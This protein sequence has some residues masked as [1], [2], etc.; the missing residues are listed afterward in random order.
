MRGK[1]LRQIFV[2]LPQIHPSPR[3]TASGSVSSSSSFFSS[4][5]TTAAVGTPFSRILRQKSITSA[6]A[7]L[8]SFNNTTARQQNPSSALCRSVTPMP[9]RRSSADKIFKSA[10][11]E[12]SSAAQTNAAWRAKSSRRFF[13]ITAA[14]RYARSFSRALFSSFGRQKPSFL[15]RGAFQKTT[16]AFASSG[17][18]D[19]QT[20]RS[21]SPSSHKIISRGKK[22]FGILRAL[23]DQ[24]PYFSTQIRIK[25]HGC[26]PSFINIFGR[27]FCFSASAISLARLLYRA[28]DNISRRRKIFKKMIDNEYLSRY[29][30]SKPKR[31]SSKPSVVFHR[32]PPVLR[33]RRKQD[34]RM[35]SR[36]QTQSG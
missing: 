3:T 14:E 22:S 20:I 21:S 25:R 5:E 16:G 1:K 28:I 2:D 17:G 11:C 35:D 23:F 8:S 26:T 30:A 4:D 31:E 13:V 33:A 24:N 9:A 27:C 29:T 10:S 34:D 7:M 15:P 18:A 12:A 32:K 36:G 6:L 19:A